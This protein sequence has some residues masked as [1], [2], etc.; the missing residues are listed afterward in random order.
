MILSAYHAAAVQEALQAVRRKHDAAQ[1][2]P[3]LEA[4]RQALFSLSLAATK[5]AAIIKAAED[6]A[7]TAALDAATRKA[8]ARLENA[9]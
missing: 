7:R 8:V 2:A 3:D 6:E 5:A 1:Q 9:A 4:T